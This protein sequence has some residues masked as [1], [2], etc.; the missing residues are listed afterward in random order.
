M[1][2]EYFHR[3]EERFFYGL[4]L[5][6]GL[7]VGLGLLA[8]HY[9]ETHGHIVTGMDNQVVWGTPHIFAIFLIVAASGVLNVASIGSVFGKTVYK[10][11]APLS[12]LL[13][14]AMLAGGL[15]VLMLDL[16][17]PD[18]LIVAMTYYNFASI[19]AW[20]VFLYTGLFAIVAV[21]LWALMERR[22][23]RY[24][25]A[26]G[27]TAFVWRLVLTTGTGSIFGFLVARQA[28]SSAVLAPMFIVA[29]FAWGLAV[30]CIVQSAMF[31][32]NKMELHPDIL[33]RMKNLLGIF[34]A[35]TAYFVAVYHLTNLYFAKQIDFER[36][37]LVNGGIYPLLFWIGYV[38]AGTAVPLLLIYHPKL[39]KS[40]PAVIWAS[41]LVLF[42][43]FALLYVLIIGGQ[44]FPLDIFPGKEVSSSFLDGQVAPYVPSAPEIMLG[45]GGIGVAFLI[46]T[47]GV[48]VLH[49]LPQDDFSQLQGAGNITD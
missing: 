2:F 21:Y 9:M 32:W 17:R 37:I 28:Y 26:A 7:V 38:L 45:L 4:V 24:S 20:N 40:C 41:V 39:G 30:F 19:F 5:A 33:R 22:M 34:L 12:G 6:G 35:G 15:M 46:T 16:G 14:I 3:L 27:F 18:R 36:F 49:F 1:Q 23:N 44:A 10:T 25:K 43:A 11:R 13:S 47:I 8:A 48:R 42:G 31:S 29:S